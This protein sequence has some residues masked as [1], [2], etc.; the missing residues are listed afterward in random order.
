MLHPQPSLVQSTGP[1]HNTDSLTLGSHLITCT[2]PALWDRFPPL[3]C[4][5]QVCVVYAC[6]TTPGK[7][8]LAW[9]LLQWCGKG[10]GLVNEGDVASP[11][12]GMSCPLSHSQ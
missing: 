2:N 1:D 3:R 12:L 11:L 7:R 10:S 8:C 4:K 5:D 6:V 9:P